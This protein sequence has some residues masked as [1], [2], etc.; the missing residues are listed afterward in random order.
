MVWC[1]SWHRASIKSRPTHVLYWYAHV[2]GTFLVK[3]GNCKTESEQGLTL[4]GYRG[5]HNEPSMLMECRIVCRWCCI[6][7]LYVV[8]V[9]GLDHDRL[10][11][12][13]KGGIENKVANCRS[14][15]VGEFVGGV[16]WCIR[17]E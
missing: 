5:P 13:R 3:N 10:Q 15:S 6:G 7:Y 9:W 14:L 2:N 4:D 16:A 11:L 1:F 8:Y 17:K 12:N